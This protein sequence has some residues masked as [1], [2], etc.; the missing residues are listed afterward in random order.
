MPDDGLMEK[1]GSVTADFATTL[2][3]DTETPVPE[4]R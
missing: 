1:A 2:V 4:T 3:R